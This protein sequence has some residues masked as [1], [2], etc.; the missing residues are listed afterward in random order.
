MI[1]FVNRCH[2]RRI[3]VGKIISM[4]RIPNA[5]ILYSMSN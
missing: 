2:P 1:M 5:I 3:S 4:A